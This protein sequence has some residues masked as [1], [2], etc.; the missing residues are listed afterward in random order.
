[1]SLNEQFLYLTAT[2]RKSGLPRQIEIWFVETDGRLYILAE[3]GLRAQ[4]VQNIIQNRNVQV[5]V[6]DK[7]WEA[8]TR[9]LDAD[10]D[11]ELYATVQDL[12]RRKYGWGEGLPVEITVGLGTH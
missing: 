10:K 4:W 2:G 8:T 6:G 5:R 7:N 11:R 9:V 12:S 3:H 1:M